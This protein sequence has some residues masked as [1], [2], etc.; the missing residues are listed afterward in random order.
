M[1]NIVQA[2]TT[3]SQQYL[4]RTLLI[5]RKHSPEILVGTGLVA[6]LATVIMGSK[7]TLSLEPVIA[8]VEAKLDNRKS[9]RQNTTTEEYTSA[10]YTRDLAKI[11]AEASVAIAKI[12]TPTFLM[13]T[14][15]VVCVLSAHGIMQ[16]RNA[17]LVVAYEAVERAYDAY[18]KRV[19]E[20]FG[21][22]KDR[23][24]RF[25]VVSGQT[26]TVTAEDGTKHR[27]TDVS[28]DATKVGSQY[29]KFFDE[30]NPNW[31]KSPD[32]NLNYVI[33]QQKYA[34]Q[35]LQVR[36]H[37]LLNDVYEALGFD[38]TPAGAVVGWVSAD[39]GTVGDGYIDFGIFDAENTDKRAFVNGHERSILLDFNVDG[40]IY[41]MI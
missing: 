31:T 40:V 27:V 26:H 10:A 21:E 25:G 18:R 20:E 8:D 37:V 16:R 41:E 19:I 7:A 9:V 35:L 32:M 39:R 3:A 2:V 28:I 34:N 24:Y 5:L 15:S 12:Y 38:R 6:G 36:G 11:Y 13:G 17:A 1:N 14:T 22:D 4:G 33:T 30:S 23:D 29:A